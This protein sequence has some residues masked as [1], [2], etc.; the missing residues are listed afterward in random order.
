[1]RVVSDMSQH[2][3]THMRVVSVRSMRNSMGEP[4]HLEGLPLHLDAWDFLARTAAIVER[5]KARGA[6]RH[7][8][9]SATSGDVRASFDWKHNCA[10]ACLVWTFLP[11]RMFVLDTLQH[12]SDVC[13]CVYVCV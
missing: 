12:Q 4:A 7:I 3:H 1:M 13:A 6:H 11:I 8:A 10:A 9:A 5:P 2:P